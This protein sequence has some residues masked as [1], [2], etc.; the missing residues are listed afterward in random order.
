[1]AEPTL[2]KDAKVAFSTSTA[3][4]SAFVELAGVKSVEIPLAKAELANSVMGD[5][6]ETFFPGLISAPI[7]ITARQDFTTAAAG[8]DALVWARWNSET[9]FR[10][11]V[12]PNDTTISSTNPMYEFDRVGIFSHTPISGAHGALLENAIEVRLLSGGAVTRATNS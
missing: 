8:I 4:T 1:M 7:T 3:T 12:A 2:F 5:N 11:Q 9:K 6:A 10:M